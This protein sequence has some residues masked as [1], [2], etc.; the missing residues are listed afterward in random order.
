M[1]NI[2]HG[3]IKDGKRGRYVIRLGINYVLLHHFQYAD[4]RNHSF[5]KHQM[6]EFCCKTLY[7]F[8]KLFTE[9]PLNALLFL[10]TD[11]LI[12]GQRHIIIFKAWLYT[13]LQR[14]RFVIKYF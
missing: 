2:V 10:N 5:Q 7:A 13:S 6:K 12:K 8:R 3:E 4:S 9:N 14:N 11:L 1:L